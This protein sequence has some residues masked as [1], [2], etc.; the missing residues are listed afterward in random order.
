M[1]DWVEVAADLKFPEGPIAM[2]D[3]SV[4][5][6]EM[7]GPS[8]TR[9]LPDG[10]TERIADLGG[11]PNGAA[12][13]PDGAVYV[14]NNGGVFREHYVDGVAMPQPADP[15]DYVGGRIQRVDLATGAVD[16]LYTECDGYPLWAPND[17][18]FDGLGGFY[19]TDLGA[20]EMGDHRTRH[21]GGIYYALADGSSIRAAAVPVRDCNGIGLS[22]DGSKLYWAETYA[23]RLMQRD[24]IGPGELSVGSVLDRST[25]LYDFTDYQLLDS[26]AVDAD[27]NVCA[28]TLISG[29]ITTVSP[30]GEVL[31]FVPTGDLATTNICFGGPDLRTA[32]VTVSGSS[33]LLSRPWP[34]AGA[35][36][37]HLNQ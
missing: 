10:R 21:L 22:P 12:V 3:G 31:E 4:V 18:V 13:G 19:F 29:G 14:C 9:V 2:P 15:G 28:A 33:R 37:H 27:G 8:L 11:G 32:F 5:L 36:L 6:V 20:N 25:C 26:L 1:S 17:I 35:P 7:F 24:V 34:R 23:G 16:V 30:A